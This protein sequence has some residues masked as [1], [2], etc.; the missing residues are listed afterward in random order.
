[1]K[2]KVDIGKL[3]EKKYKSNTLELSDIL[4]QID[5]VLQETVDYK[6]NSK[7]DT[8]NLEEIDPG[9]ARDI[10]NRK[11][12]N[13]IDPS[14]PNIGAPRQ[15]IPGNLARDPQVLPQVRPDKIAEAEEEVKT[16]TESINIDVPDIFSLITN[17]NLDLRNT[18]RKIINDIVYSMTGGQRGNWKENIQGLQKYLT[19]FGSLEQKELSG[20]DIRT[21]VSNLIFIN[22]LKK[23]SFSIAQPG[24]LFEYIIAPLID[25]RA[26]VVG[27]VDQ[28]IIDISIDQKGQSDYSSY[29][30]KFFTGETSTL[31][32]KGSR[33][34]LLD[35]FDR[36]KRTSPI[37]YI[38]ASVKETGLLRFYELHT[39]PIASYFDDWQIVNEPKDGAIF[40]NST[41]N[42]WGMWINRQANQKWIE[43]RKIES[44]GQQPKEP[45]QYGGKEYS[46]SKGG[47]LSILG[48]PYEVDNSSNVNAV[49]LQGKKIV[50][51]LSSNGQVQSVVASAISSKITDKQ[52]LKQIPILKDK[53]S[54]IDALGQKEL[55]EFIL[56]V[57]QS[58][59]EIVKQFVIKKAE[60]NKKTN[61]PFWEDIAE[62]SSDIEKL[63]INKLQQ[64]AQ[65]SQEQSKTV[66][67]EKIE[68]N[69]KNL[70]Q[71]EDENQFSISIQ[72]LASS[73]SVVQLNLGDPRKYREVQLRMAGELVQDMKN[74]LSAYKRLNT[75]II[76]FFA[77]TAKEDPQTYGNDAIKNC[78]AI[79]DNVSG[80]M[81]KEKSGIK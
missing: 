51:V 52:S 55:E 29:S 67:A 56:F 43:Q 2:N 74:A 27:S 30:I 53:H 48:T 21:A 80:F 71:E 45:E 9:H 81:K 63:V 20:I 16:K 57:K 8:G 47:I 6:Y 22:L 19:D 40:F 78:E 54:L 38:I 42:Q 65:N 41:S 15:E 79:I 10:A 60:N 49:G 24:K 44:G 12:G 28:G 18:D 11:N 69:I 77:A 64:L 46:A 17:S 68:N 34:N 14:N 13:I 31:S 70:L 39:T 62:V 75:N 33:G 58:I 72:S 1:M 36:T 76:R 5:L 23:I 66:Q 4:E 35:S 26:K 61:Q 50:G 73:A 37:I 59:F 7:I 32:I 25:S 3:I